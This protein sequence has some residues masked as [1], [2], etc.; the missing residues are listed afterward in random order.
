[1]WQAGVEQFPGDFEVP[2][3]CPGSPHAPNA[4]RYRAS[5]LFVTLHGPINFVCIPIENTARVRKAGLEL[6]A[7]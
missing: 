6:V 5:L 2:L 1:M 4:Y 3:Q 7:Q